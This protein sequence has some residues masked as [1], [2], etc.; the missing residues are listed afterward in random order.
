VTV[1]PILARIALVA[2][3]DLFARTG[4]GFKNRGVGGSDE[5]LEW[6]KRYGLGNALL[7]FESIAKSI[8][9]QLKAGVRPRLPVVTHGLAADINTR[10]AAVREVLS[11][12]LQKET[13]RIL[14]KC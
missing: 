13:R 8:A 10:V 3:A 6:L 7:W 5:P 11:E 9:R 12:L 14:I 1:L 2:T 4:A